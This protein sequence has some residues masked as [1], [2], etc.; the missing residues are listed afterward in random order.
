MGS[1]KA[2]AGVIGAAIGLIFLAVYSLV[3]VYEIDEGQRG[4]VT[5]HGE[6][7]EVV[8]P[9]LHWKWPGFDGVQKVS[10]GVQELTLENLSTASKDNYDLG[11]TV[12]LTYSLPGDKEGL[13]N[14]KANYP[15]YEARLQTIVSKH[16]KNA[17]G[18]YEGFHSVPLSR[19]RHFI[20]FARWRLKK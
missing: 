11:A 2:F 7:Q 6:F 18:N 9:G 3:G 16:W 12:T 17:V 8:G 13:R 1:E 5:T 19:K 20:R 15:N 10:I 14:I 4:I